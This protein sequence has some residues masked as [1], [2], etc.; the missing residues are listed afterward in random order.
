[1]TDSLHVSV[2]VPC[3]D[4]GPRVGEVLD[5]VPDLVDTIVAV[6][7]AST[8]DTAEVL[9]AHPDPRLVV[10]RHDENR[11]VGGAVVTGYRT[12]MEAGAD[13]CVKVDGD[14]QMDPTEIPRLVAPLAEGR[15]EYAKGNRFLHTRELGLMPTVRMLGNGVLSFLAKLVSGYWSVFDPTNGFTAIRTDVLR[16]M[17]LSGLP[18]GWFFETGMLIELSLLDARVEDVEIPARYA[19]E[20]SSLRILP[21][22]VRFPPL[23]VKGLARRFF[24]RYMIRDFNAVTV[25]VLAALPALAFGVIF[26]GY[27]WWRSLETGVPAT[28][29]TTLLAA[30]PVLLGFQCLLTAL[31]LDILDEPDGPPPTAG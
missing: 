22:L 11:G 19:D 3:Y 5:A 13:I 2:V 30:L 20:E 4:E 18:G 7:D 9:A 25:C 27:H 6:D 16:R 1:M 26:G 29:G 15:A 8:D 10:V 21:V 31:V 24:W 23:L 12:A 28:A 14:G 17:D